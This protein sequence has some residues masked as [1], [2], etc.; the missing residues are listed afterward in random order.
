MYCLKQKRVRYLTPREDGAGECGRFG[1]LP[2]CRRS[3]VW[4][5]DTTR[6]MAAV[7]CESGARLEHS[8][9]SA[10]TAAHRSAAHT[11]VS[12]AFP[13]AL[14]GG[15]RLPAPLPSARSDSPRGALYGSSTG[16]VPSIGATTRVG[17]FRSC[18]SVGPCWSTV[19]RLRTRNTRNGFL[20][21]QG[22]GAR[23]A[24]VSPLLKSGAQPGSSSLP[25]TRKTS[26]TTSF[27]A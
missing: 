18:P 1:P 11:C 20:C 2:T 26:P 24:S 19:A 16:N 27:V 9:E 17:R 12:A 25:G 21:R 14:V 23:P 10:R 5:A 22:G 15:R 7:H 4:A 13:S 8:C 3:V 6:V